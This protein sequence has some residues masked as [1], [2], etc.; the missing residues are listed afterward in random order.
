MKKL[1]FI[2]MMMICVFVTKAQTTSD[3]V[4]MVTVKDTTFAND[5]RL[6]FMAQTILPAMVKFVDEYNRKQ[7]VDGKVVQFKTETN[8]LIKKFEKNLVE[9]SE[10]FVRVN[11]IQIDS[12]AIIEEF[13]VLN[14]KIE[15][16][17]SDPEAKYI[18]VMSEFKRI[19]ERQA[20]LANYYNQIKN[21]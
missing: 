3:T 8:S 15:E 18:E 11:E 6:T 7:K 14:A 2:A 21:K 17:Q 1:M 9:Y 12:T 5:E 16:L 4:S 10:L 19:T 13:N 20:K